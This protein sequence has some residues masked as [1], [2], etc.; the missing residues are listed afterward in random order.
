MWPTSILPFLLALAQPASGTASDGG[1]Q[2][3]TT[4]QMVFSI[5]YQI[6]RPQQIS[7]EPVEVQLFVSADRGANWRLYSKVEP[8]Q[9]SFLF[10][11]S[12]DGEYWFTVRTLDRSGQIRPQGPPP[13]LRVRI[14]TS[15]PTLQLTA[16]RGEA[17]QVTAQWEVRDETLK[18]DSFRIFYRFE[19]D[20]TWQAVAVS[21]QNF[22][23]NGPA[24]VGEVTWWPK[25]S[26]GTLQVRAECSDA[27]GNPAV[28]HAQ[29]ILAST[30]ESQATAQAPAGPPQ[31]TPTNAVAETAKPAAVTAQPNPPIAKQAPAPAPAKEQS[32]PAK[33]PN[34]P[35]TTAV[36]SPPPPANPTAAP[37]PAPVSNGTTATLPAPH[38]RMI[39]ARTFELEYNVSAATADSR[40]ELWSTRD[41]GRTW[42]SAA[43]DDDSRSPIVVRADA[44]GLYGYRLAVRPSSRQTS[45][46]PK[47]GEQPQ[48]WI[49]VDLT[50]PAVRILRIQP[51]AGLPGQ[52]QIAWEASDALL[53][54]RPITLSCATT[55][56]GPWLP[57]AGGL[58]NSGQYT[59]V[60]GP[61]VPDPVFIRVEARD[62][63]GNMAANQTPMPILL[64]RQLPTAQIQDVRP[65]NPSP[66]AR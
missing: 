2:P 42:S 32:V 57:I 25:K 26:Q 43:V 62:A 15:P 36:S 55:P 52:L 11:A 1:F 58:E 10:R 5:P 33:Q 13:I 40:V 64:Q 56:N 35:S 44:E 4:R 17:G 21:P 49:G 9:G 14:D 22:K 29:V 28:S 66:L 23:R 46:M 16:Q 3:I 12:V 8:T 65:A 6:D 38:P 54:E 47:S 60:A 20:S 18:R 61:T 31:T 30:A 37:T 19:G 51:V 41:G 53:G 24:E 63:A 34:D 45:E 48:I 39:N 7:Q 27:A 50:P 59:W